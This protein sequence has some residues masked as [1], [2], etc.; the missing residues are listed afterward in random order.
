MCAKIWSSVSLLFLCI[1]YAV[2]AAQSVDNLTVVQEAFKA[3]KDNLVSGSGKGSYKVYVSH[4]G[5]APKWDLKVEANAEVFFDRG[6]FHIRLNYEKDVLTHL[7]FRVIV[8]DGTAVLVNRVSKLIHPAR[9]E[10]DVYE[11]K[12]LSVSLRKA[13]F[14]YNPCEMPAEV[15]RA[16]LLSSPKFAS[17]L[18]ITSVANR[19]LSGSFDS[20]PVVKCSFLASRNFG[21]NIVNYREVNTNHND[22]QHV[23]RHATWEREKNLWYVKSIDNIW[24]AVDNQGERTVFQYTNFNP[25]VEIDASLFKFTALTLSS[26]ARIIDRRSNVEE[27][28]LRQSQPATVDMAKLDTLTDAVKTL[29]PNSAPPQRPR[30]RRYYLLVAGGLLCI[31]GLLLMRR[32]AKKGDAPPNP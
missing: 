14:D 25:N 10:G 7:D 12:P 15:L 21:C 31:V 26:T 4:P 13:G 22:F 17:D 23:N 16:D 1:S 28:V 3:A 9:S 19:D 11:V 32:R 6:K 2:G 29:T 24:L 27:H 18:K 30:L 5:N 20:P 8:Y